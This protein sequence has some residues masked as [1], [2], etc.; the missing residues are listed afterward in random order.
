MGLK[1]PGSYRRTAKRNYDCD[2]DDEDKR[3]SRL[4]MRK[5]RYSTGN[6]QVMHSQELSLI[7]AN[8]SWKLPKRAILQLSKKK[9]R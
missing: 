6:C 1:S 7:S 9:A 3:S 8:S 4:K 5:Q 2:E